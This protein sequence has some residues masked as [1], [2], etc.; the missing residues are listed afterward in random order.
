[1]TVASYNATVFSCPTCTRPA[2]YLKR[3]EC[4]RCYRYRRKHGVARPFGPG[5]GFAAAYTPERRERWSG[6]GNPAWRG[7]DATPSALYYRTRRV[8]PIAGA[9]RLCGNHR[10]TSR[11][12]WDM[13]PVNNEAGNLEAVYR[14]C[15]QILHSWGYV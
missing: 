12:H 4:E 9:C 11:H 13:N 3:G 7:D 14:T 1:M 5:N 2:G 6:P 10:A 15:H 8:A